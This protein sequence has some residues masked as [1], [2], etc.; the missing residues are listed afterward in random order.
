[1]DLTSPSV[2]ATKE[3]RRFARGLIEGLEA[4]LY[5]GPPILT[6]EL[7]S[8]MEFLRQCSFSP[9]SDYFNRLL[10]IRNRLTG[11][12]AQPTRR[13]STKRNYGGK[14]AGRWLQV[15]SIHDHV[16][17][18]TCFEGELNCKRGRIKISHRFNAAG[19][20]DFVELKFLRSMMPALN[21]EI[22]KL[23]QVKDY[24]TIRKDWLEAE[25]FTLGVLPQELLF[26]FADLFRCSKADVLAWLINIGHGM[27][28]DVLADL[29]SPGARRE[30]PAATEA[31]EQLDLSELKSD[32]VAMPILTQATALTAVVE[33]RDDKTAVVRYHRL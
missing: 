8:A 10:E 25:A 33:P 14:A 24:Q 30:S 28:G 1:M 32:D 23:I 15:Q 31:S 3:H 20:I 27:G 13:P 21:G 2:V 5:G 26:L 7:S 11:R 29:K 9:A 17:L 12:L 19:R 4:R 16:I 22:R 18:S 6:T